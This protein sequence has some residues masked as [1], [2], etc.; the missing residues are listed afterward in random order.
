MLSKI[1][2]AQTKPTGIIQVVLTNTDCFP[3]YTR[4]TTKKSLK[5]LIWKKSALKVNNYTNKMEMQ[6]FKAPE[7]MTVMQLKDKALLRYCSKIKC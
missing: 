4:N 6:R 5:D 3:F 7:R 1:E 2:D